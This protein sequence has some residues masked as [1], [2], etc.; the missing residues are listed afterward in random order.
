MLTLAYTLRLWEFGS[1]FYSQVPEDHTLHI[2]ERELP[3]PVGPL[4]MDT[5]QPTHVGL[6]V[7]D[8]ASKLKVSFQSWPHLA[9][10]R[11]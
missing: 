8:L 2:D 9:V 7:L 5:V 11:Q 3:I 10:T 6:A 1:A 4:I